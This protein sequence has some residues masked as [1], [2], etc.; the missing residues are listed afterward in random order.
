MSDYDI[1]MNALRS[2]VS[3]K[4]NRVQ[5]SN[6]EVRKAVLF[7]NALLEGKIPGAEL[8]IDK[9]CSETVKDLLYIKEDANGGKVKQKKTENG[10]TF[11]ELGHTSDSLTYLCVTLLKNQFSA[12]EKLLR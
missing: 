3:N 9:G 4:A 7:M 2:K 6:P 12:F 1:A 10:V 8:V 5:R 11:E